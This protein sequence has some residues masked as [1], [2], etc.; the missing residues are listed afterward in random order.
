MKQKETEY[1]L[2]YKFEFKGEKE[3]FY[4]DVTFD[5]LMEMIREYFDL[6]GVDIDGKDSDVYNSLVDLGD[7]VIDAIFE[8][9]EEQFTKDY[10]EIAYKQFLE[11]AEEEWSLWH[12]EDEL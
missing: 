10:E 7:G 6:H 4:L 3:Y 2:S 11:E 8:D 12:E 5:M 9:R 1:Y